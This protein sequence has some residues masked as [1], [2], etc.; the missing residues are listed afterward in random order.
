MQGALAYSTDAEMAELALNKWKHRITIQ[1]VEA[2]RE[3]EQ[4]HL[5]VLNLLLSKIDSS[6]FDRL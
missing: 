1:M 5:E 2:A 6:L 3:N 4:Y